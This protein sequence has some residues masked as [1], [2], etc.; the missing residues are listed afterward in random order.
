MH[1]DG[2]ASARRGHQ[3]A[4]QVWVDFNDVDEEGVVRTPIDFAEKGFEPKAGDVIVVGD[5]EGNLA[6]GEV[7]RVER[8][9]LIAIALKPGA[10]WAADHKPPA[11]A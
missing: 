5:D 1:A 9:G 6:K 8:D 2:E 3:M 7:P 4:R 10:F 11:S